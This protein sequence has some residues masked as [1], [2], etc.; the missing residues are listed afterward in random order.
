MN[1]NISYERVVYNRRE[2]GTAKPILTFG[3]MNVCAREYM[4]VPGYVNIVR[5]A[6]NMNVPGDT[7][8]RPS[9]AP[10]TTAENHQFLRREA[11]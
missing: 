8:S 11:E 1:H 2:S 9:P 10:S 4:R 5:D 3:V 7:K 6:R